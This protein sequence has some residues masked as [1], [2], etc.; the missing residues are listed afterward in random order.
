MEEGEARGEAR[1]ASVALRRREGEDVRRPCVCEGRGPDL[2]SRLRGRRVR[3]RRVRGG[4]SGS[5]D[6]SCKS[7]KSTGKVLL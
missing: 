7:C 3:G 1:G 2:P 5:A 4:G 6:V